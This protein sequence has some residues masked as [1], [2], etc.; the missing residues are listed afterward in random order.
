MQ[1]VKRAKSKVFT[2]AELKMIKRE[3]KDMICTSL[4][5]EETSIRQRLERT[6]EG[7]EIKINHDLKT[8]QSRI[9]YERRLARE[10]RK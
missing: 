5:I 8:I 4:A 1:N 10:A 6:A 7:K 3:F 9:K 2:S